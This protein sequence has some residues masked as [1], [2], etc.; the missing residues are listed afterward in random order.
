MCVCKCVNIHKIYAFDF[1]KEIYETINKFYLNLN[2][3]FRIAPSHL[4]APSRFQNLHVKIGWKSS[5]PT[6]LYHTG[7][8]LPL[9]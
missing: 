3:E 4:F 2:I 1:S 8:H 7:S 5:R 9:S 6:L